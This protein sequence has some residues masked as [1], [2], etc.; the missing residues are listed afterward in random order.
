MKSTIPFAATLLVGTALGAVPAVAETT[1]EAV[2]SHY[3][4]LA[5]AKY[6][7]SLETA[8]TLDQAIEAEALAQAMC[9]Q[10]KDFRRAFEAFAAKRNPVFEGD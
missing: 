10:T 1:P 5:L 7:D 2:A 9:M 6:S 3:A 8:R 4:D